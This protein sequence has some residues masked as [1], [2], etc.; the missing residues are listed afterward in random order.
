MKNIKHKDIL[1][2]VIFLLVA[3]GLLALGHHFNLQQ[4]FT[5]EKIHQTIEDA[6]P[7]GFVIF[8]AARRAVSPHRRQRNLRL[9]ARLNP[10]S[11]RSHSILPRLDQSYHDLEL[12]A[13]SSFLGPL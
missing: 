11:F 2:F 9:H 12:I 5:P 7:W 4:K 1:K 8:A 6:G 13:W 3:L 10:S